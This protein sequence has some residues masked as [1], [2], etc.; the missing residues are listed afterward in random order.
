MRRRIY[1]RILSFVV[2]GFTAGTQAGEAQAI[3]SYL[4]LWAP[5]LSEAVLADQ[6]RE[7]VENFVS[8]KTEWQRYVSEFESA[9]HEILANRLEQL[10]PNQEL[11]LDPWGSI[12]QETGFIPPFDEVRF[13]LG[14]VVDNYGGNET[15]QRIPPLF[16]LAEL[17]K[18]GTNQLKLEATRI[19]PSFQTHNT[20][21]YAIVSRARNDL[22]GTFHPDESSL[23][24]ETLRLSV[25]SALPT[26]Y[27]LLRMGPEVPA[28]KFGIHYIDF[29]GDYMQHSYSRRPWERQRLGSLVAEHAT[30][31]LPSLADQKESKNLILELHQAVATGLQ[32]M[33]DELLQQ[34]HTNLPPAPD[35]LTNYVRSL[36]NWER[37]PTPNPNVR[38]WSNEL[39]GFSQALTAFREQAE[40]KSPIAFIAHY[41]DSQARLSQRALLNGLRQQLPEPYRAAANERY[42]AFIIE[43]GQPQQM[44][45]HGHP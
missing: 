31:V 20:S 9:Y 45:T 38:F 39:V 29:F 19:D 17:L 33:Q 10:N 11:S 24:I 8:I 35:S 15:K 21:E 12:D 4:E 43:S 28:H 42:L 44:T 37:S 41:A 18:I 22:V 40:P 32:Q 25:E 36:R 13:P 34:L 3:H 30:Q 27:A 23:E 16:R 2:F 7:Q 26:G 5:K 1:S 6:W 14:P